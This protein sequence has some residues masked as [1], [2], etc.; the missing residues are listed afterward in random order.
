[1]RKT[2]TMVIEKQSEPKSYWD[3]VVKYGAYGRAKHD[4]RKEKRKG[5]ERR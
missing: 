4:Q 1:M 3:K 2:T 5:R